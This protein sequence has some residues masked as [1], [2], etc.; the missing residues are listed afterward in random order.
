M[1]IIRRFS[2]Q[3]RIMYSYLRKQMQLYSQ[4]LHQQVSNFVYELLED[5]TDMPKHEGALKD[6]TLMYV[7]NLCIDLV[8]SREE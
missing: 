7:C 4:M 1:S 3:A 8:L 5:T 2:Q 6:H